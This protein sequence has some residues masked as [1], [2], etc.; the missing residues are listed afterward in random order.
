MSKTA[1]VYCAHFVS[2]SVE[3]EIARLDRE[4]D[5][6]ID[7][8]VTG[9]SASGSD[10]KE[11]AIGRAKVFPYYKKDVEALPYSKKLESMD[12]VTMRGN[13]DLF[14]LC[15]FRDVKDYDQYWF[16]EYDVRYTGRWG[17]LMD[18]LKDSSADLLCS[19]TATYQDGPDWM[20]WPSFH[21]PGKPGRVDLVRAFL[22]FC[23]VSNRLLSKID[24]NCRDGW[25]GHPE[26]LWPTIA[27][28][29]GFSLEEIGGAGRLVPDAR[30]NKYYYSASLTSKIFVSTFGAWPF[31]SEKSNFKPGVGEPD[32]LW[33]PVKE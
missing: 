28:D 29:N 15:F 26:V 8:F 19:Y 33:H 4:L 14:L 21:M 30:R 22:P 20:F 25:A 13:P 12:W 1:F 16:C 3:R 31:Y 9:C 7:L 10:L 11:L 6:S 32:I 2:K 23:R 18:D 17:T 27:V 5:P 24:E